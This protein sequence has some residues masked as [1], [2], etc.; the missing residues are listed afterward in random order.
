[1]HFEHDLST[2]PS[3]TYV[4][5]SGTNWVEYRTQTNGFAYVVNAD[6][7]ISGAELCPAELVLGGG[8]GQAAVDARAAQIEAWHI[9]NR[10]MYHYFLTTQTKD[11]AYH[12]AEVAVGDNAAMW[13]AIQKQYL[14]GTRAGALQ[15]VTTIS[16]IRQTSTTTAFCHDIKEL[17]RDLISI[18][19]TIDTTNAANA[20]AAAAAAAAGLPVP[21]PQH[22][23]TIVDLMATSSLLTGLPKEFDVTVDRLSSE[24]SLTFEAAVRAILEKDEMIRQQKRTKASAFAA[25]IPSMTAL[26][27]T[28]PIIT[29]GQKKGHQEGARLH[30]TYCSKPNHTEDEC[31]SKHPDKKAAHLKAQ[32]DARAAKEASKARAKV[33]TEITPTKRDFDEDDEF[34]SARAARVVLAPNTGRINQPPLQ[35]PTDR[36]NFLTGSLDSAATHIFVTSSTFVE[37]FNPTITKDIEVADGR[38]VNSTGSGTINGLP[39]HVVPSFS[40]NLI[41]VDV[42]NKN[43]IAVSLTPDDCF[44]YKPSDMSR[45]GEC[46]RVRNGFQVR[47]PIHRTSP[48]RAFPA[49]GLPPAGAMNCTPPALSGTPQLIAPFQLTR[50]PDQPATTAAHIATT[51]EEREAL[52]V[53]RIFHCGDKRLITAINNNL[54]TGLDPSRTSPASLSQFQFRCTACDMASA[55]RPTHP[56]A[57]PDAKRAQAPFE[58]IFFDSKDFKFPSWSNKYT[59]GIVVDEYSGAAF[60][61]PVFGRGD[62]LDALTRFEAQ[63]IKSHGFQLRVIRTDG[64]G[65]FISKDFDAWLTTITARHELTVAH[66]PEQNGRAERKIRT[67]MQLARTL[68]ISNNF[69]PAS[70]AEILCSAA[71]LDNR[72]P[73]SANPQMRS[74]M[75]M[76]T[77]IAPSIARLHPIGSRA[78]IHIDP[79]DPLFNKYG[80][81]GRPGL[82]VGY[83]DHRKA[84]RILVDR[85]GTILDT[86]RATFQDAP[87]DHI[88]PIFATPETADLDV[89]DDADPETTAT[90]APP[91]QLPV[92]NQG[93]A[94][95]PPLP[96]AAPVAT[97]VPLRRS[98]RVGHPPVRL[99][100]TFRDHTYEDPTAYAAKIPF[101]EAS[102]DSRLVA[103]MTKEL[104][105]L[106]D[107]GKVIAEP[108]PESRHAIGSTWAH[109]FKHDESNNPTYAKSRVCPQ[110]FSQIPHVDF[111]P[112]RIASPTVQLAS[113]FIA[114][115]I[116]VMRNM[117]SGLIDFDAAFSQLGLKETIYMR[118][119]PGMSIPKGYALRLVNALQG[120]R[121][122]AFNWWEETNAFLKRQN[123]IPC[124][125]DCCFY[126]RWTHDHTTLAIVLLYVDDLRL[127]FDDLEEQTAFITACRAWLPCKELTG[128]HYL[129]MRVVHDRTT[130]TLRISHEAYIETMLAKFHMLDCKPCSTPAAPGTKLTKVALTESSVEDYPYRE[131]VGSLLWLARCA[132][133]EILYAVNQISAHCNHFDSSHIQAVKRVFRYVKGMRSACIVLHQGDGTL[134]LGAY[135]DADF[136]GEPDDSSTPGRSLTGLLLHFHGIGFLSGLSNLQS[137][138]SRSTQE[139]EY[140]AAGSCTQTLISTRLLLAEIGF[141]QSE[142]TV[143]LMDNQAAI[144]AINK[145]TPGS[146]LRHIR[147]DHHYIRECV[148][149]EQIAVGYCRTEHMLADVNTKALPK[150]Q[151]TVLTDGIRDCTR[152][153]ATKTVPEHDKI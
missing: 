43:G 101:G 132:F 68:R 18:Q 134:R 37:D 69:P 109:R 137:T 22:V 41:S 91:Q 80:I 144:A 28:V 12:T 72:L 11:T 90:A 114:F 96:P 153:V 44:L 99:R 148:Q 118:P 108:L 141:P 57:P 149:T 126:V 124:H 15:V 133:P 20:A 88:C 39:V 79:K 73:C 81:A 52:H 129:G 13:A 98:T 62:L 51:P 65:E 10:K 54:L 147:N 30:C 120:L 112:E 140:R 53:H 83:S 35:P 29:L 19:A 110:G 25:T 102:K 4:K 23:Q 122:S 66:T 38:I 139:A 33:A 111:N 36:T 56:S 75:Q 9:R 45:V 95:P 55:H 64:A 113:V 34:F 142:P 89:F 119:P 104:R 145:P 78:I 8:I 85:H 116:T 17:R 60:V 127:A 123:F 152:M 2:G 16:A 5:N 48:A 105:D 47:I 93:A 150:V 70:W 121:Q 103:S 49:S 130:G 125:G 131:A 84:W 136:M 87:F 1:M 135:S 117:H 94:I 92:G 21:I 77:G 146:S 115:A 138:M 50:R 107:N 128:E 97:Q 14:T 3:K 86:D 40:S 58:M 7:I 71:Y 100:A 74:P 67:L 6:R 76:L 42:L 27:A 106:I 151:F 32:A 61:L 63:Y 143:M 82:L 46:D 24:L 26:A 59:V 31:F